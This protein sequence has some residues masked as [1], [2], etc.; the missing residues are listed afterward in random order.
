MNSYNQ[1]GFFVGAFLFSLPAHGQQ[2]ALPTPLASNQSKVSYGIGLQIGEQLARDKFD[3][4]AIDAAALVNG[5]QDALAKKEPKIPPAEFQKAMALVHQAAIQRYNERMKPVIAKNK[6]QG[7][8]F[9]TKFKKLAGVKS[10]PR[11]VL[12]QV[13]KKGSGASPKLSD[14]VRVHYQGKLVNG[15]V[16]DS[17]TPNQPAEFPLNRVI[18]GWTEALQLMKTGAKWR[19]VIPSELG[20]GAP[21]NGDEIGPHAVLVFEVELLGIVDPASSGRSGAPPTP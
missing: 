20:Y 10:T 16:F 13:L 21:G 4:Q 18:P 15:K 6:R 7:Q 14:V 9:M 11:G 2:D 17:T 3:N 5:I 12:Y 8:Q 19:V 1:L